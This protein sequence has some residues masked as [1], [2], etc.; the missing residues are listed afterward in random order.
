[1]FCMGAHTRPDN[2]QYN[3]CFLVRVPHAWDGYFPDNGIGKVYCQVHGTGKAPGWTDTKAW[4]SINRHDARA[5]NLQW[6][7]GVGCIDNE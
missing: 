3:P 2:L 7:W 6:L 5:E 1:M 4:P